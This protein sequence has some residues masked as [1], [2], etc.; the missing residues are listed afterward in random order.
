MLAQNGEEAAKLRQTF[1]IKVSNFGE[2]MT[3]E[4]LSNNSRSLRSVRALRFA[5][6]MTPWYRSRTPYL[7]NAFQS[8]KMRFQIACVPLMF[9]FPGSRA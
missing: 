3:S 6:S 2:S 7:V 9:C 5:Q 1:S 4:I 8:G